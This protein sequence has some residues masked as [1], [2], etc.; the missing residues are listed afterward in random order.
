MIY[1]PHISD[2]VLLENISFY[3][4]AKIK[5]KTENIYVEMAIGITGIQANQI[6]LI[7]KK[8]KL[9]HKRV[10]LDTKPVFKICYY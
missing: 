2:T 6:Y 5:K 9:T 4:F 1:S 10:I 8:V 3:F 7:Y